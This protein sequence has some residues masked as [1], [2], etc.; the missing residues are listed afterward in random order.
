MQATIYQHINGEFQSTVLEVNSPESTNFLNQLEQKIKADYFLLKLKPGQIEFEETNII[1]WINAASENNAAL[2]YSYYIELAEKGTTKIPTL[3]YT[4]GSIRDD[5]NFGALVLVQ[6]EALKI[7]NRQNKEV[8][9]YAGWYS[10]RLFISRRNGIHQFT[11][12]S[13]RYSEIDLRKSGEKQFDYVNPRNRNRQI[14]MEHA[15][16]S[17]LEKIGAKVSPPFKEVNFNEY[18]FEVEATVII[19]V[20]NREKTIADA[21]HSV[22]KQK[23]NFA[24]NLIIV[25][26]HSTDQTSEIIDSI[27]DRRVIHIIPEATNL[28]IGGCWN[29]GIN[30]PKCGRFAI[31]L[32]SDDL[33]ANENTL[34]KI[35]D[36]FY[37]EKCAMVIGSYQM[38]NFQLEE[39]PPGIIDHR[40]WTDD[41]GPNNALRINGLGAPRAFY[42]PIIRE[43]QFPNVSYGEDY[44]VALAISRIWKIG[45]I[46]EPVYLCRRWDQNTDSNLS[47]EKVNA[48][49]TYKDSL[50]TK[51]IKFRIS[52]KTK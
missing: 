44:A 4:E 8:Y 17:H 50:R 19:P 37:K 33:Y 43:I 28:G 36:K 52:L 26:N 13:Y 27:Q 18:N 42:T 20:L 12:Y 23:T 16:T 10:F 45:R 1:R 25:D 47:I 35:I 22:L 6:K 39:I 5:F 38:V 48:H 3:S 30:H 46:Y 40:E 34:Q 31:Q 2:S 32:D 14:D 11:E 9:A 49:N 24:F 51:E 29:E 41:N 15:V 7:F 21:I